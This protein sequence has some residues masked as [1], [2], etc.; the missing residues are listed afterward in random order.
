[1]KGKVRGRGEAKEEETADDMDRVKRTHE[2]R[3]EKMDRKKEIKRGDRE[4]RDCDRYKDRNT[5]T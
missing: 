4:N 1:M 3:E 5:S 2:K